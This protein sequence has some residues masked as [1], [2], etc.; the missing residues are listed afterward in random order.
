[1]MI[2]HNYRLFKKLTWFEGF[3]DLFWFLPKTYRVNYSKTSTMA[4]YR[5]IRSDWYSV[6]NDIRF[7]INNY[8]GTTKSNAKK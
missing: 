5:A 6:G 7:A 1:M 4:D 3:S 2:N 8:K